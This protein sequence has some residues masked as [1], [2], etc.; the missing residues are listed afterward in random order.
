MSDTFCSWIPFRA[1]NVPTISIV[2][3]E[4][5]FFFHWKNFRPFWV[6]IHYIR[7]FHLRM[8]LPAKSVCITMMHAV[9]PKDVL[10]PWLDNFIFLSTH[11]MIWLRFRFLHQCLVIK[12][13][14]SQCLSFSRFLNETHLELPVFLQELCWDYDSDFPHHA[15]RV[16]GLFQLYYCKGFFHPDV[17][18]W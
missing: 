12:L 9:I 5:I 13:K 2:L 10:V 1:K 16:V 14:F 18:C 4:V 15:I 11:Y 6:R 3:M 7:K 8:V 17:T